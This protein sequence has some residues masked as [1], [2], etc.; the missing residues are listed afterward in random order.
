MT[1]G[2]IVTQ[3]DGGVVVGGKNGTGSTAVHPVQN[4]YNII[5]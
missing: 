4:A 5:Y 2:G 3:T 1:G